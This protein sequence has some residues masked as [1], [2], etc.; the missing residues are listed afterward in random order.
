MFVSNKI[1]SAELYNIINN[2][3]ETLQIFPRIN[4]NERNKENRDYSGSGNLNCFTNHM[5]LFLSSNIWRTKNDILEHF[6]LNF[7][8]LIAILSARFS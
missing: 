5:A 4:V 2:P 3:N 1:T 8:E 7:R 6:N